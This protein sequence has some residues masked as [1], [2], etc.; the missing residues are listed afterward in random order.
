MKNLLNCHCIGLHS[1][2]ISKDEN[3]L[4]KRI[5]YADVNHQLFNPCEIAIH[6]HHVNIKITILEGVLCNLLYSV[7]KGEL[8]N[9]YIWK[10]HILSGEGKF[11][12]IGYNELKLISNISYTKG[13]S[14]YMNSLELH[15]VFVEQ[16]ET[17]V[18]MIEE[19]K[20]T[21]PY[22]GLNFSKNNLSDWSS[23]G[24]YIECDEQIKHQYLKDYITF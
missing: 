18:W 14:F 3:G 20:P 1:F 10:S 16:F 21:Y 23:K 11:K 9:T 22:L 6:P 15:T 7:G 19:F 5:F 24:L 8:F 13:Q 4:Y 17:C 12:F 2:P